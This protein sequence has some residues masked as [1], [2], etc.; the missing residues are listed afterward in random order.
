MPDAVSIND[1]IPPIKNTAES[2]LP[3]MIN[4]NE[5]VQ[6]VPI[7]VSSD[8]FMLDYESEAA[9]SLGAKTVFAA[10]DESVVYGSSE[11]GNE[12]ICDSC[13]KRMKSGAKFCIGC[14]SLLNNLKDKPKEKI[15]P[16]CGSVMSCDMAFC[17]ECG[18][19]L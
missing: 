18:C 7:E 16:N 15:C 5:V 11:S 6:S 2:D 1:E 19:R 4:S 10:S 14:G 17:T 3:K 8:L 9:P 13:G 12:V